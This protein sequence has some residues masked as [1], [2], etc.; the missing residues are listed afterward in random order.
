MS[1]SANAKLILVATREL[2]N[3]WNTTKDKW[4][5]VKSEQFEQDFILNLFAEAERAAQAMEEI[6]RMI[7]SARSQGE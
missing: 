6:D 5:D 4:H 3:R 1:A 7:R 2:S